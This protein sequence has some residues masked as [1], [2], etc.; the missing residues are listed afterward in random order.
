MNLREHLSNTETEHSLR[1]IM[2]HLARSGK[3]ISAAIHE[4]NRKLAGTQNAF[5]EQQ[6]ELD[7]LADRILKDR[8]RED[9]SFGIREFASEEQDQIT[10]LNDEGQR[11]STTVD[12]LDGSSLVDV[13]L[14]VGTIMG[15]HEGSLLNNQ[16]GRNSLVAS[17]YFLYGPLTTL[18]YNAGNGTHEFV[19]DREGEYVL[20][21]ENIEIGD[22]NIRSPG[23]DEIKWLPGHANFIQELIKKEYKLRYSGA[24]V[25]DAN[26]ILGQGGVFTYPALD[27]A[28]SGKLRLLLELQPMAQIFE[29]AGGKATNGLVDILDVVPEKLDQ[30]SPIYLG[31]EEEIELAKEYL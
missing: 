8:L 19:L 11:Y 2:Y 24:L 18:V 22:G 30:R 16:S 3:Y 6:L 12:P 9:T 27:D 28:P 14:A 31:G 15:V 7:V 4:S 17:M 21:N 13:N 25:A 29:G 10:V 20:V 26:L 23:G 1:R 5:G